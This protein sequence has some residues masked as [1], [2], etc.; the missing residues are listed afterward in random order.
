MFPHRFEGE[1]DYLSGV[2]CILPLQGPL[3]MGNHSKLL[4]HA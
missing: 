4:Q 2:I 3:Q 1:P